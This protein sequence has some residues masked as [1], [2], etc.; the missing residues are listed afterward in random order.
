MTATLLRKVYN[1]DLT[2][3]DRCSCNSHPR[4]G[5]HPCRSHHTEL[6][7]VCV[8]PPFPGAEEEEG[9]KVKDV[10]KE[11]LCI[12]APAEAEAGAEAEAPAAAQAPAPA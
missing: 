7:N 11:R 12:P 2:Y 6:H 1:P 8:R 10:K 9:K 5:Y 3:P 4:L